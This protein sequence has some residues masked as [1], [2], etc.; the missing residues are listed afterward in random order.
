[1]GHFHYLYDTELQCLVKLSP[2]GREIQRCFIP[3]TDIEHVLA[4]L[5]KVQ[6]DRGTLNDTE[7]E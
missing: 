2:E 7:V 1:M 4:I 6:Y 3:A 5:F